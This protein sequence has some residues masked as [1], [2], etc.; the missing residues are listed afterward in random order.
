MA[1]KEIKLPKLPHGQGSFSWRDSTHTKIKF[2]RNYKSK[3]D[4]KTYRLQA[5]ASTVKECYA[6]IEQK[7]HEKES[8]IKRAY[9]HSLDNRT[10]I[11]SDAIREWLVKTKMNKNKA[12]SFDRDE[13]TLNNQIEKY[14]IGRLQAIDVTADDIA[15]HLDF[16]LY[17]ADNGVKRGY[18]YS[19][20]KKTYELLNQFFAYFYAKDVNSNPMRSVKRPERR[21]NVSE[22]SLHDND[23]PNIIADLVLSDDEIKIFKEA[24]MRKPRNGV[25]GGT[26]YGLHLYFMLL[27]FLRVGEAITLVWSDVDWDKKLLRVNKAVSRVKNRDSSG[28]K[29]KVILT[30]PKTQHGIRDVGLTDE[31]LNV[32]KIIKK[33]SDYTT[34]GDY[35]F[36]T[37]K[38]TPVPYTHLYKVLKG[39]LKSSGLNSNGERD[40][41]TLHYLRH[42]GISFYIRKGVP[43]DVI[44]EMAGHADTYIT[45]STYYHIINKQKRDAILMM[46]DIKI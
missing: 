10:V 11:L 44:S 22:I 2:Q 38:G 31:A 1:Q 8:E 34:L 27:T 23:S 5:T 6:L 24:C 13:C 15:E 19:V 16:L 32:L 41:F 39:L 17:S 7:E 28:A 9:K 35:I 33:Q 26:K 45:R 29:T 21:K 3:T 40:G 25:T 36:A 46:N 30:T 18:S 20:V 42:S 37:S 4:G 43:L 14:D 12:N